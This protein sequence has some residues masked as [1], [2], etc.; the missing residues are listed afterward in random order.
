MKMLRPREEVRKEVKINRERFLICYGA[1]VKQKNQRNFFMRFKMRKVK[2]LMKKDR[3]N[4]NGKS[5]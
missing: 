5:I 3:K 1:M 4:N 2:S